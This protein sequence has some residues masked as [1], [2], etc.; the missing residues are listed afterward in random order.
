L[1]QDLAEAIHNFIRLNYRYK[2]SPRE[3]ANVFHVNASYASRRFS[4]HYN[5]TITEHIAYVRIKRAKTLLSE[6]VAPIGNIAINV[7]FDDVNYF[8]RVFKS[9]TGC[10]PTQYRKLST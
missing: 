9:M 10:T 4:Q 6:T 5:K 8:S 1:N 2:I 3:I 7:G